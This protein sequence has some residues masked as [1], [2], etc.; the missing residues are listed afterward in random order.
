MTGCL[1]VRFTY[2]DWS[3][4]TCLHKPWNEQV[5]ELTWRN[6]LH[7]IQESHGALSMWFLRTVS[8]AG[9]CII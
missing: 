3:P 8:R 7:E 2:A 6:L 9:R 4:N 1:A 5:C